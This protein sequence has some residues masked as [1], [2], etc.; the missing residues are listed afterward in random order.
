MNLSFALHE[1]TIKISEVY[2]GPTST[3]FSVHAQTHIFQAFLRYIIGL[4]G[5]VAIRDKDCVQKD[6]FH[7][8]AF[9]MGFTFTLICSHR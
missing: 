9:F 3:A 6:Y 4:Q 5:Q 1:N 8:P 2:V 7:H